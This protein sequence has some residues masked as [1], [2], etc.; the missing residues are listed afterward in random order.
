MS[1]S[2]KLTERFILLLAKEPNKCLEANPKEFNWLIEDHKTNFDSYLRNLSMGERHFIVYG[3]KLI[4]SIHEL[5]IERSGKTSR[6]QQRQVIKRRKI[7]T[8]RSNP[9]LLWILKNNPKAKR[10][11]V[12]L[13]KEIKASLEQAK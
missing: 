10:G 8:E 13:L 2:A 1:K 11:A 12:I 5:R 7:L 9:R 4:E 6:K 3:I